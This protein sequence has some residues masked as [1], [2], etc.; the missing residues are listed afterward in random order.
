LG[1]R[2]SRVLQGTEGQIACSSK[3]RGGGRERLK[4]EGESVICVCVCVCC[5]CG[6]A[7]V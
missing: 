7:C 5:V 4:R 6:C 1:K 2:E 3:F